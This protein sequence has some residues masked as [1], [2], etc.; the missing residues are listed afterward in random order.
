LRGRFAAGTPD[1]YSRARGLGGECCVSGC[2]ILDVDPARGAQ[3]NVTALTFTSQMDTEGWESPTVVVTVP[4][5]TPA[6]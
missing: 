4:T 6:S 2:L 3:Q 1:Y 5:G